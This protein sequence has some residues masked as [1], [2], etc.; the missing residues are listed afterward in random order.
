MQVPD[1]L[2]HDSDQVDLVQRSS[3]G[4]DGFSGGDGA[5]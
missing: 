3:S 1:R 4:F 5:F 2:A